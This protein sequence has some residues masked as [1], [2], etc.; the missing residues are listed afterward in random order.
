MHER[1]R[2]AYP[3]GTCAASH[4]HSGHRRTW[5]PRQEQAHQLA[6]CLNCLVYRGRS[7]VE[8]VNRSFSSRRKHCEREAV[9]EV[10]IL[11]IAVAALIVLAVTSTPYGAGRHKVERL[12][13]E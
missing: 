6:R 10:N 4:E 11:F 9:V 5:R 13:D 12:V 8:V 1:L 3:S 2:R 7:R